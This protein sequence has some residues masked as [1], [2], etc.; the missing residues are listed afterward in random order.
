MIEMAIALL[1]ILFLIEKVSFM[2][3][4]NRKL[5]KEIEEVR[6]INQ[7]QKDNAIRNF[8]KF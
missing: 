5:C 6:K 3:R 4:E 8:Q 1:I 7:I 2:D